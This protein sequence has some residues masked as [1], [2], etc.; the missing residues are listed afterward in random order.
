MTN[1][2]PGRSSRAAA[3]TTP[4]GTSSPSGPQPVE[5]DGR[6]VVGDLGVDRHG[7][8]RHV[9][10]VGDDDVDRA[11]EPAQR[12][13]GVARGRS[14]TG[15]RPRCPAERCA[16]GPRVR[17]RR[18]ARRRAPARRAPRSATAS[19]IAPD[20]VHRSTTS[21]ARVPARRPGPRRRRRPGRP[22]S[23]SGRGTKTP[24]PDGELQAAER[25]D[26]RQV[27][28]RDPG[29][30]PRDEV[31]EAARRRRAAERPPRPPQLAARS[32]RAGARPAAPRRPAADGDP[33]RPPQHGCARR[34]SAHRGRPGHA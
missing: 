2:P 7:V 9:R 23:V 18:R 14:R 5:R 34:P 3:R 26:A 15:D 17:R 24:G 22:A 19:A 10:R 1:S 27:L 31:V 21:A 13:A 12:G 8:G 6:V 30:A 4:R 32:R 28:Q 25:R 20:P 16:P 29:G 11:V 33:G